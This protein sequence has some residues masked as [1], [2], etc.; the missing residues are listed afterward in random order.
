MISKKKEENKMLSAYR[1]RLIKEIEEIPEEMIPKVYRIINILKTE[2]ITRKRAGFR[3]SLR[4]I[5][6]GSQIDESLFLEAKKA[7]F[8]YEYR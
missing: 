1:E 7:I 4:G 6:K 8:P 2:L 5:W 3:G